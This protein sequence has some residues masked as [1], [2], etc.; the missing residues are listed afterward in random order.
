MINISKY[1]FYRGGYP[2]PLL[3]FIWLDSMQSLTAEQ[4]LM[5]QNIIGKSWCPKFFLFY[6]LWETSGAPPTLGSSPLQIKRF[7]SQF[8]DAPRSHLLIWFDFRV[9]AHL[10]LSYRFGNIFGTFSNQLYY[11][12][13]CCNFFL[14]I[15]R[16]EESVSWFHTLMQF[17]E[18]FYINTLSIAY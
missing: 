5:L 13:R 11:Q 2:P 4:T 10:Q 6:F 14:S 9:D 7:A 16:F 17:A 1:Q 12:Y 15:N 3:A 8:S 18:I